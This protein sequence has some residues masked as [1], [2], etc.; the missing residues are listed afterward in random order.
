MTQSL[1]YA[2]HEVWL[3]PHKDRPSFVARLI[4]GTGVF[5]LIFVGV[6]P[7]QRWVSSALRCATRSSPAPSASLQQPR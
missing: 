6:W 5:A 3:V 4:R 1:Q 2:F 7:A